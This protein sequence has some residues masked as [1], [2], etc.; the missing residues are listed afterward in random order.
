MRGS[1]F[2][3]ICSESIKRVNSQLKILLPKEKELIDMSTTSNYQPQKCNFKENYSQF[4]EKMIKNNK[5]I[6]KYIL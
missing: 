5:T 4:Y 2:S 3:R 6:L 1:P